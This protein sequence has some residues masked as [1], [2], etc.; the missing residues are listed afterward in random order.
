MC[1]G[2]EDTGVHWHKNPE[3]VQCRIAELCSGLG[4]LGTPGRKNKR[5][6]ID[7]FSVNSRWVKSLKEEVPQSLA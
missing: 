3:K 4:T 6:H 5:M 7:R 1:E 2:L